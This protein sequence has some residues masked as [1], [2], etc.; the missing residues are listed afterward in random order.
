MVVWEFAGLVGLMLT[1]LDPVPTPFFPPS[2]VDVPIEVSVL[3][4]D[5]EELF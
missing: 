2:P 1:A 3:D 4:G 5:A